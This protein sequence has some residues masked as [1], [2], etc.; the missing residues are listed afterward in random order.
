MY[1][2]PS[3]WHR[4]WRPAVLQRLRNLAECV[5][6]EYADLTRA[7]NAPEESLVQ[8]PPRRVYSTKSVSER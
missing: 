7:Q 3:N 6:G 8:K 2:S 5:E 4:N 1:S